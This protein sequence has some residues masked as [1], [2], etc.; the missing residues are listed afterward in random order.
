MSMVLFF[1]AKFVHNFR[2]HISEITR[3]N[4]VKHHE[5]TVYFGG[6]LSD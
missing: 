6:S 4:Q 2:T 1:F 3:R 5:N